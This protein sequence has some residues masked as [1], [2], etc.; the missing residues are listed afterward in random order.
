[1]HERSG[2][3]KADDCT[4]V[5]PGYIRFYDNYVPTLEVGTYLINIAQKIEPPGADVECHV[6]S[7][8][9]CVSGPRYNLPKEDI[10]SVFP[11][12]N[13]L[14]N[15]DQY[16][17]HIVLSKQELPWERNI[18][19]DTPQSP[20]MALLLF[21]ADEEIGGKKAL[22]SPDGA[23]PNRTLTATISARR[24]KDHQTPQPDLTWP[25]FV[26]EWYEEDILDTT[27][28]NVIDVS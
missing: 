12:E 14:G 6:A 5:D 28:C 16:L 3:S 9:F 1:L 10:A 17:P 15:F 20:W 11:P 18:F 22:R 13:A 21:V 19:E 23:P 2:V 25:D 24:F 26:P 8:A 4:N 27:L 7:Q